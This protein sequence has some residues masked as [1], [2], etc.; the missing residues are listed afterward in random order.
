ME[1]NLDITF[2]QTLP[3]IMAYQRQTLVFQL[4]FVASQASCFYDI[5]E[6]RNSSASRVFI[7][8]V[9]K[10]K[11]VLFV[12]EFVETLKTLLTSEKTVPMVQ[13]F[14]KTLK[15]KIK[16]YDYDSLSTEIYS[17]FLKGRNLLVNV[18][19]EGLFENLNEV[20][21][22]IAEPVWK[23]KTG[24]WPEMAKFV[25]NFF[26]VRLGTLSDWILSDILV[27]YWLSPD[28]VS[29]FLKNLFLGQ[30]SQKAC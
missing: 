13:M 14:Y 20:H 25:D 10:E 29:V 4:D 26:R 8:N 23:L 17:T 18:D 24:Q 1:H 3:A 5:L 19:I 6:V 22:S 30:N 21:F 12:T 11:F 28:M 9:E 7:K 16:S 27:C 15:S 2:F